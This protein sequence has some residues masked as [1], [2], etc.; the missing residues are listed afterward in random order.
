MASLRSIPRLELPGGRVHLHLRM[1]G[2]SISLQ[3]MSKA[4]HGIV[5]LRRYEKKRN[6][7]WIEINTRWQPAPQ[8]AP[9]AR[10]E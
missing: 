1:V 7:L 8:Y 4:I 2:G 10:Q 9:I 5:S 3:K 6:D